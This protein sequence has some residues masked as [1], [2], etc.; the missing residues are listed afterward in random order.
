MSKKKFSIDKCPNC[1]KEM[2]KKFADQWQYSEGA[3]HWFLCSESCAK[4]MKAQRAAAR[5]LN[6][7]FS[8]L[9]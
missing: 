6:K 2:P 3:S 1:G 9:F 8:K 4:Q 7:L 5:E